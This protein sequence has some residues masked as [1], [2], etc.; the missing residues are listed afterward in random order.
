MLGGT[1]LGVYNDYG[2]ALVIICNE[3]DK[4]NKEE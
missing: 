3:R 1:K 4:V 2:F